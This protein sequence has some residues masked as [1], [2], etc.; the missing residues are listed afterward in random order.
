[1]IHIGT[2]KVRILLSLCVVMPNIRS[3]TD[4]DATAFTGTPANANPFSGIAVCY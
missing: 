4:L 1:M 2:V 3:V